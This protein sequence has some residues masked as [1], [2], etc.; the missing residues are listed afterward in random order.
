[1]RQKRRLQHI[2]NQ[3]DTFYNAKGGISAPD[4]PPL[5]VLNATF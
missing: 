3:D 5:T 2:D 1:M 4:M